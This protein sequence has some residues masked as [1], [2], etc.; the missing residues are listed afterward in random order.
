MKK[1]KRSECSILPL[2]LKKKWYDLIASGEKTEE[3][4]DAKPFWDK[5]INKWKSK[6]SNSC[7][8]TETNKL[9]VIG[10]SCGYKK[11]DMFF[12]VNRISKGA[13]SVHPEWGEPESDHWILALREKVEIVEK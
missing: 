6:Q 11:P 2:V 8:S 13:N 10:F 12:L 4:R 7:N 5:R 1:L 3:Y 9:Q